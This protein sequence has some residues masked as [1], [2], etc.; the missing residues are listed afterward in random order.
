MAYQR[1]TSSAG[2]GN[3]AQQQQIHLRTNS[4]GS[5]LNS[6]KNLDIATEDDVDEE[7][8]TTF[9][10]E[11]YSSASHPYYNA[12]A[13]SQYH[14]VKPLVLFSLDITHWSPIIQYIFLIGGLILFMCL[15][16]YY[17][18]LVI[19]GWFN[20]RL[21]WFSTFLHFLGCT[22]FAQ[23]Q[24]NI[25]TAPPMTTTNAN[26]E[27][28]SI[29]VATKGIQGY[30]HR[31]LYVFRYYSYYFSSYWNISMGTATTGTA[32]G[33]YFLLVSMKTLSQGLSNLSMTE[34]N[35][36]AKVL[37]KSANPI[38]TI[39]LGIVW[40][41]KTYPLKDYIVVGLLLCG[42]YVFI[43]D[44]TSQKA[45]HNTR[46]ECTPLGIFYVI[47]SMIG[48]ALVPMIQ[49]HAITTYNASI[50]DLLYYCFLGSTIVSLLLSM[51]N[52][53]FIGGMVFLW[54]NSSFHIWFVFICF[55]TFG[56]VGSNFSTAITAHYGSLVNGLSN[57]IRKAVTMVLSFIMFPERNELTVHKVYGAMIF[58]AGL[59]VSTFMGD[60]KHK[61]GKGGGSSSSSGKHQKQLQNDS[62]LKNSEDARDVEEGGGRE[63]SSL[64]GDNEEQVE[65]IVNN[66]SNHHFPT[67]RTFTSPIHRRNSRD[68][69]DGNHH[70]HPINNSTV[71]QKS[72]ESTAVLANNNFHSP[73]QSVPYHHSTSTNI[74]PSGTTGA[75]DGLSVSY[76][77]ERNNKQHDQLI[78]DDHKPP[79][80][81]PPP[82]PPFPPVAS[83]DHDHYYHH[84]NASPY[85]H[86]VSPNRRSSPTNRNSNNNKNNNSDN[87]VYYS[88]YNN[89]SAFY[90]N[91]TNTNPTTT[92]T[93]STGQQG[94]KNTKLK[95]G[96]ELFFPNSLNSN[97][98]NQNGSE[99]DGNETS[100]HHHHHHHHT[101]SSEG[102]DSDD[103]AGRRNRYKKHQFTV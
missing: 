93:N 36:P 32:I 54:N 58:F 10:K 91:L 83:Q 88:V 35:Y 44:T 40:F 95:T 51:I 103:S 14:H 27:P 57:T 89:L 82:P 68:G 16:G 31:F 55:C 52:G 42:L 48:S 102:E 87:S 67:S 38:I 56:F 63:G 100:E 59:L 8:E 7:T 70:H 6:L 24:R 80:Q 41:K 62:L 96:Q 75:A 50:E 26:A 99:V 71:K 65:V 3:R 49:E 15:Y 84:K 101:S 64:L 98:N 85:A 33:Y 47:L 37:F 11:K 18:E 17:Q 5:V 25:S 53:E 86:Q 2:L 30:Y 97:N 90:Q 43:T 45:H 73:T 61:H 76:E 19:Y 29:P 92:T 81:S 78:E 94:K 21:S 79:H 39:F 9:L 69:R 34:I 23:L 66:E 20:R 12:P 46:P 60:E 72:P 4:S 13:V 74:P 22:G 28:P 77:E 1:V